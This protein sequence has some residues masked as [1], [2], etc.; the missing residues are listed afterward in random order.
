[1]H[2]KSTSFKTAFPKIAGITIKEMA[3]VFREHVEA[4]H[5]VS[6]ANEGAGGTA[7]ESDEWH[8]CYWLEGAASAKSRR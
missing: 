2:T 7:V 3:K 8:H 6:E 1:M 4:V 5:T